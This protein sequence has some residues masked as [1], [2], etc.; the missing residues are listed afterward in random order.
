MLT[1]VLSVEGITAQQQ[2]QRK[3]QGQ[4]QG[5]RRG[6]VPKDTNEKCG[7]WASIGECEKNP[8]YVRCDHVVMCAPACA[9]IHSNSPLTVT[10]M[11]MPPTEHRSS[12]TFD[13]HPDNL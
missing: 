5:Q 3:G 11:L 6:A 12:T 13:K 1:M 4:G 9:T 2:Q 7:F 8:T 10:T